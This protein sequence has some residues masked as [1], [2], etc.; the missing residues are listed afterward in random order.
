MV[1]Q[2]YKYFRNYEK[3]PN[4]IDK[5]FDEK[6]DNIIFSEKF[7]LKKN[8]NKNKSNFT[9]SLY[10]GFLGGITAI[11][12]IVRSTAKTTTKILLAGI[13]I[14][15]PIKLYFLSQIIDSK[16]DLRTIGNLKTHKINKK[17]YY[18]ENHDKEDFLAILSGE[19]IEITKRG[20]NSSNYMFESGRNG[21]NVYLGLNKNILKNIYENKT[22]QKHLIFYDYNE[23]NKLDYDYNIK[24]KLKIIIEKDKNHEYEYWN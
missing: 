14:A 16:L 12:G 3:K 15:I 5:L 11:E 1:I 23:N 19:G 6:L 18:I 21:Y 13:L 10:Y 4:I 2:I 20:L 9:K 8:Y 7:P 17:N 22:N 24:E